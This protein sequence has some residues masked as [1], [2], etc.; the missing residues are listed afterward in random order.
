VALRTNDFSRVVLPVPLRPMRA[1][2]SPRVTL[3]EKR[4][5]LSGHHKISRR[6]E[7]ERVA[8]GGALHVEAN[9]GAL[10]VGPSELQLFAGAR[11]L[12]CAKWLAPSGCRREKR[13]IN[14]F[15]WAIF[16]SRWEFSDSMRAR[17]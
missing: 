5:S 4:E 1:I 8:A 9:V 16:F 2:F 6:C 13:A 11:L 15:S 10:D 7:L 3:A 17:M 14:S 12:S